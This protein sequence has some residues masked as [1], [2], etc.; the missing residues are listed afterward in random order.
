MRHFGIALGDCLLL[1]H[2]VMAV[3][4]EILKNYGSMV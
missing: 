2:P 4:V 3:E 1:I